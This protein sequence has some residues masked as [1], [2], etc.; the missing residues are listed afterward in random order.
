MHACGAQALHRQEVAE[1]RA[2]RDIDDKSTAGD[3]GAARPVVAPE[4]LR[5]AGVLDVGDRFPDEISDVGGIAQTQVQPLRADRGNDMG[6]F[7]DERDPV[8]RELAWLFDG[9]RKHVTSAFD[10]DAPE[11]GMRL[12]FGRLRE[13]I[14]A[15]RREPR[16]L[17]GSSDPHHAAAKATQRYED[18][19]PVRGVKLGGHVLVRARMGDVEGQRALIE[20]APSYRDTCRLP[21]H[22]VPAV[23]PDYE[24]RG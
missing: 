9:K 13:F 6:G 19:G 11:N 2:V 22:R 8:A 5:C 7:A 20:I 12:S 17:P 10:V 4:H 21:A 15:E 3:I 1:Q 14:V 18:A 23:G 16:G 24:A